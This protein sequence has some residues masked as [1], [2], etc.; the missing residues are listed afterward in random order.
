MPPERTRICDY[1]GLLTDEE[2]SDAEYE[3]AGWECEEWVI[4]EHAD[5]AIGE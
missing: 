5:G 1:C 4:A 3:A 2:H